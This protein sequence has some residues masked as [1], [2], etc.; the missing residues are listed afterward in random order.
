M[1]QTFTHD[2]VVYEDLG[3]GN[4][5]AIGY[6]ASPAPA[7]PAMPQGFTIGSPN[8]VKQQTEVLQNQ[9]LAAEIARLPAMNE[10]D[11]RGKQL[12]NEKAARD[13]NAQ[14][15]TASPQ[16]QKA[17]QSL[18][19]DEI[20]SAIARARSGVDGGMSSGYWARLPAGLQPQSAVDLSG[21]L[22]TVA[23]RI[24]LDTLA[25]LKQSSPTGA[26]GLGSL[27]EQEGALL[28]DSISSLN[29]EQ[30]PAKLLE[31]LANVERHY[32]NVKALTNGED[33]R[34]PAV[35]EKYGIALPKE[36]SQQM[37][38]ATGATREEADP[39]LAGVNAHIRGMIGA[40]RS[41]S[42]I[43][44]YMNSIQPGL[45]DKRAADVAGAVKFRAQNPNFP[46]GGYNIS[47][48]NRSV[49]MS[50]TRQFIN[51]HAQS[52]VGA[53]TLSA[54]DALSAGTLDNMTD[55]PALTRAGMAAVAGQNP[56]SSF[57]GSLS[58]GALA[59]AAAETG[60]GAFG[61]FAPLAADVGYG[62]AYGAGSA[63]EGSRLG[64]ALFGAGAGAVGGTLGRKLGQAVGAGLTGVRTP[65]VQLLREA[66]VPM[67]PG[68][69]AGQSGGFGKYLKAREDRLTGYAGIGDRIND[70]RRSS[71]A[72]FNRATSKQGFSMIPGA[73][74]ITDIGEEG[75]QQ[76]RKAISGTGGAYD[77][78]LA[79][80]SLIP[81]Q[82]FATDI[83]AAMRSGSTA[84][85]VGPE[86]STWVDRS[87]AP[88]FSAPNGQI[89]GRQVQDI[90]QQV[91]KADFG[92][93]S[94][95]ALASD[96]A[97][98]IEGAVMDLAGR[99]APGSMEALGNANT[100]YRNLNILADAVGRG[101]NNDGLYA[102]A[103]LGMAARQNATKFGGKIASATP[104]R[105]F[106]DLQ[107]AAQKVLP[108]TVPDSGTAGRIEAGNG[109]FG[110]VRGAVRNVANAP[111]YSD[112]TQG[113]LNKALLDRPDIAVK[114][115]E[116]IYRR[117]RLPGMFGRPLA[118]GYGPLAVTSDY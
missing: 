62:A 97:R 25:K 11:L 39:A 46:M 31:S 52:P 38:L 106:Y 30:S 28:R 77:Q 83:G 61:R 92:N 35:A 69:I 9:R 41:A 24:T 89:N 27:T 40:G 104:D 53:Y 29:Q 43:V 93:D 96:A 49:P 48:E 7:T 2:G 79:G 32:R 81:D 60:L 54:L 5:R 4:V 33:Y 100:A 44:S 107:R 37:G 55:N 50:A 108:S 85:R 14:Q 59:G 10:A 26:S 111:L 18:A 51:E 117:K 66:G 95:G 13:L 47:V 20:L 99:Q 64:G 75:I 90:L 101:V 70:Q 110:A 65:E 78:A 82:Q 45:G 73:D 42:D 8:P 1:A 76:A 15:A 6:A 102:P 116:E 58:G 22:R 86:F 21:D 36:P 74:Q 57:L 68:Q 91:R 34:D 84:A 12:A 3:D 67:T 115:G 112:T 71:I 80:V 63:D 94:M 109:L 118:L 98:G 114:L 113:F 23:S 72:G 19:D 16:Q 87:I 88:H 56:K 103:Q 105:P 17:M